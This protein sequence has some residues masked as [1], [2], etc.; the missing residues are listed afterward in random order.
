MKIVLDTNVLISGIFWSGP[1]F[2]ILDA[3]KDG[4]IQLIVT[5]EILMEYH[6]VTTILSKK[7]ASVEN[8]SNS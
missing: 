1:P 7:F 3:W 6:R 5:K 4:K 8:F 2:Q